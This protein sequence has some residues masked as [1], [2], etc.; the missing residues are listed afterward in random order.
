MP[1]Q[2]YGMLDHAAPHG[3][4]GH[5]TVHPGYTLGT[6]WHPRVYMVGARGA[7]GRPDLLVGLTSGIT[8]FG[9]A[10]QN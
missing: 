4:H 8:V 10:D 9:I 3:Y 2:Y 1:D 5:H 6:T 7:D